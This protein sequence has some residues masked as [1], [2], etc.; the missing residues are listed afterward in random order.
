MADWYRRKS[1]TKADE[2]EYF[3]KLR[4]ARKNGRPQYLRVQA[5]ELIETKDKS[6]LSVAETLLHKI[7]T[8]Y[9]DERTEKSHAYNLLG[10]IYKLKG[11]YETALIYFQKSL[12]FEREFPNVISNAYL[13]FSETVVLAERTDLYGS[14]ERLLTEKIGHDT[15]KFPVQN[16][17][18]YSVMAII[19]EFKGDLVQA[20]A[21][22]DLA[23]KNATTKT[24]A[25]WDPQKR[26]IGIVK[27]RKKWLDRLVGRNKN[28]R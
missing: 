22:A 27:E 6:L 2:D 23:E 10:E 24:N 9:P 16:Y 3:V 8:D 15:L 11:N 20:K 17:I 1:W 13:N 14:V 12:D 28:R 26:K 19:S 18:I 25:L 4:R 5:V 21:F 7:L